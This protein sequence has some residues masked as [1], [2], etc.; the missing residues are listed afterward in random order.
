MQNS[1]QSVLDILQ[2]GTSY[3]NNTLQIQW[4]NRDG[5][6]VLQNGVILAAQV[7]DLTGNGAALDICRWQ[8]VNIKVLEETQQTAKDVTLSFSDI[9]TV[10]QQNKISG[11]SPTSYNDQKELVKAVRLIHQFK[12]REAID[13]ISLVLRY[14]RFNYYGWLWYSRLLSRI[15]LVQKALG[16]ARRW[17]DHAPIIYQ[18]VKKSGV[19]LAQTESERFKRC[20]FCWTPIDMNGYQCSFCKA[21]Q[22][23][24]K[25]PGSA[26]IGEKEIKSSLNRYLVAFNED[27]QND[28]IGYTIATAF[29]NLGLLE[30]ALQYIELVLKLDS[31]KKLYR[32][33]REIIFSHR[34]PAQR[35][36]VTK[37]PKTSTRSTPQPVAVKKAAP[38][39]PRSPEIMVIEDSPT[40]RKVIKMVLQREGFG[41][42][43]ASTGKE[44]LE[45][46]VGAQPN[47]ILLDVM[48]PDMTGYD[49]LP[50]LR[51]QEHL[52][53][54]PVVM[55]TG[56]KGSMDR[57]KGMLA[58]S[59]EY[60]TK[61]FNPQKLTSVIKK[62]L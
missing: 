37:E 48:L 38:A 59:A 3:H 19:G 17:G 26:K 46:S 33:A 50:E 61:P 58:G 52:K 4:G 41:I 27:R 32:H 62:Y 10:F 22:S 60:I 6:L 34:S 25:N 54:I 8:N 24:G 57:M 56:K 43:E 47:L 31:E 35:T 51:Q 23:I 2:S 18:E 30:K 16:E 45:L 49:I 9:A 11:V 13:R 7:A 5:R 44:A 39:R 1:N 28:K 55:L 14:N 15:E 12:Y 21:S 42:I 29:Y 40:A 36:T 53:E 20:L